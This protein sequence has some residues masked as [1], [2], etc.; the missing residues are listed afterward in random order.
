MDIDATQIEQI[1][2]GICAT[3]VAIYGVYK[4]FKHDDVTDNYQRSE[5]AVLDTLGRQRDNL[6]VLSDKYR[7]L[8]DLAESEIREL[9]SKLTM[10]E[11]E[12]IKL[13]EKLSEAE[14]EIEVLR[15]IL[16]YLNDS[17]S[18]T[19]QSLELKKNDGN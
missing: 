10:A 11:I 1:I 16:E 9:K 6:I 3:L 8:L 18:L 15:Q 4:R 7:S 2:G 19:R 13:I 14:A 12:N 5:V 17:V